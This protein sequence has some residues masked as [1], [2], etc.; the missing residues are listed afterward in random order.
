MGSYSRYSHSINTMAAIVDWLKSNG[1]ALF[2]NILLALCW[3]L[4]LTS[5]TKGN[6]VGYPEY[7]NFFFFFGWYLHWHF[8][9]SDHDC[10][11]EDTFGFNQIMTMFSFIMVVHYWSVFNSNLYD[12][13]DLVCVVF[14][15]VSLLLY[16]LNDVVGIFVDKKMI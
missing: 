4:P 16:T 14:Q 10:K 6:L 7:A 1:L 11:R 2:H 15:T 12:E 5:A 8:N 3:I 9:F 13:Y